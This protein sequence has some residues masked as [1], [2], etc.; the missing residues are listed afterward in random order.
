MGSSF[1]ILVICENQQ[2]GD[3]AIAA[4]V[5]E[6][7]R[8]EKLISSWDKSSETSAINRNAGIKPVKVSK[9]LFDLI[10]RSIKVSKLT[11]GAF[12]ISFAAVDK[13]CKFKGSSYEMPDSS[14]VKKS[15][16]KVGYKNIVLDKNQS[17]VFLRKRG[18]KIGFGA[19]G[20]G[21]A[22]NQ[23]RKILIKM[24]IKGGVVDASGDLITWGKNEKNNDWSIGIK[25]PAN[26]NKIAGWLNV[27]KMAVVTSGNYEKF[28][29]I[30]GERYSHIIN[31]QTGWPAKGLTSVTI[32]CPDAEVADALATSVFVMGEEKG[33]NLINR[34]KNIECF[35]V[36]STGK[37]LKSKGLKL[38]L[39][40]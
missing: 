10:Y 21:Y 3:E 31:P 28:V 23:A 22:A 34:L 39:V 40:K 37:V 11:E 35:L 16:D 29:M 33:M 18:M 25:N 19:I 27:E 8:I 38:R 32:I 13:I 5:A 7:K 24:G 30:D 14:T 9:E 26:K 6:I 20:K 15:I 17:T 12:D 2:K 1:E 36:N 4:G